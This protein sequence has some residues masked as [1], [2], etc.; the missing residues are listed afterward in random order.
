MICIA[1]TNF[2]KAW[3][4]FSV[5]SNPAQRFCTQTSGWR[6]SCLISK[7]TVKAI[8][9][10]FGNDSTEPVFI[11]DFFQEIEESRCKDLLKIEKKIR[12][13]KK[14]CWLHEKSQE[15]K[16][17]KQGKKMKSSFFLIWDMQCI[18]KKLKGFLFCFAAMEII[19]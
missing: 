19:V 7:G 15:G 18:E 17:K 14:N 3:F 1:K 10:L 11:K 2:F 12:G 16:T 13:K 8:N 9:H 6:W 4:A 5:M